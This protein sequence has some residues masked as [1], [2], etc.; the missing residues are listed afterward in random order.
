MLVGMVT[1]QRSASTASDDSWADP[2]LAVRLA[3]PAAPRVYV[4]RRRLLARLDRA[5]EV[6]LTLVSAPAGSGKTVLAAAW[7]AKRAPG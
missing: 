2:L 6:P 5:A 7:V 3:V 1:P 4:E